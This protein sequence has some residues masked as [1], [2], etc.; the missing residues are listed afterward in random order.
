MLR[1]LPECQRWQVPGLLQVERSWPTDRC[2]IVPVRSSFISPAEVNGL[3]AY[4]IGLRV[5]V[6]SVHLQGGH[7]CMGKQPKDCEAL[8]APCALGD[9]TT[10]VAAP[11]IVDR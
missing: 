5:I 10:V 8:A 3:K 1:A 6:L 7:Q 4:D 2:V 11:A 9:V